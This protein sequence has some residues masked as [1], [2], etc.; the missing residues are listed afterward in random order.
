MAKK[1]FDTNNQV[2]APTLIL[3]SKSGE[4][5]G[6]IDG[7]TE[8][9]YRKSL[10]SADEL[11]FNVSKYIDGKINHLWNS[12]SDLKTIYLPE[13]QERFQIAVSYHDEEIE[14]KSVTGTS[15]C[16]AELS[17]ILL[18][19]FSCNTEDDLEARDY[20]VTVFYNPDDTDHS[21]LN[22]V[23]HDKVSHYSIGHVDDSL[24]NLAF[25]FTADKQSIY[26]FLT[27]DIAEH[28]QCLFIFDSMTRTINAYDLLST[29]NDC[30]EDTIVR[31]YDET[32]Q[33][34]KKHYRD[35]FHDECPKCHSKNIT[36]GYGRD[37]TI[38]IDRENLS[39]EMVR[40]SDINSLKNCLYVEGGDDDINAAFIM[41]NPNGSQY[42]YYFSPEVL[43][44]MPEEF[45]DA[46]QKYN[47]LYHNYYYENIIDT[48][49][50]THK[51]YQE[52][53]ATRYLPGRETP[54]VYP[55][56]MIDT[57][58]DSNN[59]DSSYVTAFNDVVQYISKLSD[60][61]PYTDYEPYRSDTSL[62]GQSALVTAYFNSIDLESFVQTK[63][64]PTYEMEVY[65][66]HHALSLLTSEN[67]GTVSVSG[68]GSGTVKTVVENAILQAAKTIIN[69]ALFKVSIANSS[70][71][72][73]AGAD[74]GKWNGR[75]TITD[76]QD[77]NPTTNTV[78]GSADITITVDGNVE[79]YCKNR[80]KYIMSQ[81][82]LPVANNLYD[83]SM[84]ESEIH[85]QILL[86]SIDNLKI[87]SNVM[88]SC[89]D[90]LM[91]KISEIT[92]RSIGNPV[93]SKLT[94]YYE[95]YKRRQENITARINT[96]SDYISKVHKFGLLML[97]YISEVQNILD[98]QKYLE[99]YSHEHK[100]QNLWDVF[101]YYRREDTYTNENIISDSL[102]TNAD[103]VQY[104]GY[105]MDFA[106][107]EAVKAGTPQITIS[108]TLNNL[109]ALPEFSPIIDSF[110]VGNW[111]RVRTDIQNDRLEDPI[112]KLRL[113]SYK[114]SFDD[115]QSIDVEFSTATNTW[116]GLRDV[117]DV[118]ASAQSMASS[119]TT[120]AKQVDKNES[121]TATVNRW[122]NN[123]LDLTNQKI[124]SDAN[125]Q[126]ILIDEHGILGRRYDD[127][128]DVYDPC[129]I[130]ILNNGLYTTHDD[131][132]TIDAGVGK[133]MWKNPDKDWAEEE[134][135]GIIARK[136]VGEQ[137]LGEDLRITNATGS[138]T[139]DVNGLV[140]KNSKNTIS[141]NPNENAFEIRKGNEKQ[142][143]IDTDGNINLSG[144]AKI[145]WANITDAKSNVTQITKDTI[146]TENL[147]ANN[148][149]VNAANIQGKLIAE[150]IDTKGLIAENI[151]GNT[152]TGKTINGGQINIGSGNFVVDSSGNLITK[153]TMSLGN[154]KLTYDGS[155]LTVSGTINAIGG[156]FSGNITSTGT[157]TGG[158]IT[159]TDIIAESFKYEDEKYIV[160]LSEGLEI[161]NKSE[162]VE[163]SYYIKGSAGAIEISANDICFYKGKSIPY[164]DI[165]SIGYGDGKFY[166][167]GSLELDNNIVVYGDTIRIDCGST[168]AVYL[169]ARWID[170]SI[171][172]ILS[173]DTDGL[174]TYLGWSGTGKDENT[175]T[176][177]TVLRGSSVRLKS[178]TGTTVSSDERL[179]NSFKPLNE[180]SE[181]FMDLPATAFKYNNGQSGRYHFGFK[182]QDVRDAFL[183]HGYTTQDFGGFVQMTDNPDNEDY[184]GIDD[185]MGL[186]YTEFTAWNT[187]MIQ[188]LYKENEILK[189]R[190]S[191]LEQATV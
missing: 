57:T 30:Y 65:D 177:C 156:T 134:T 142:L 72:Y 2:D 174:T 59:P 67:I 47:D 48:A 38:L 163:T 28:M 147:V 154:G 34:I 116:S 106:K 161:I 94:E 160:E 81:S 153:G 15:L 18:R 180:F 10:M 62:T 4:R 113:L 7:A 183:K 132:E 133:F 21:L 3:E 105:L 176:T 63:M 14:T 103:V 119:Y 100:T 110:D 120:I 172:S 130:K 190:I 92:D 52:L 184:C 150:Q 117:Q 71:T 42:V 171:H 115:V 145:S 137:L 68:F 138:L 78:T 135:Y 6:S 31:H 32:G 121:A 158:T 140:V 91:E 16:E 77:D 102:D 173:R 9:T 191:Q 39:T 53:E 8:I 107:K 111:I 159:G 139:F 181:V 167:T 20:R 23:L 50:T 83:L 13:Y 123:G 43:S 114:I 17:Q 87:I 125:N 164:Y 143:Y 169:S 165:G 182:A 27:G 144:D 75:F 44:E 168:N 45:L 124:V 96:L 36:Q 12:I 49:K 11:S 76:L 5:Y 108:T 185:P 79:A 33:E 112:Y 97:A 73:I 141:I 54:T 129:Q 95:K 19:D 118:I 56:R 35:D 88:Q 58:F 85:S 55:E 99:T 175:Y 70:Y 69:T 61:K 136:I 149:K 179:K 82:D 151:S 104:A 84:S 60:K 162:N 64:A 170:E 122:V 131:W 66:K 178:T 187:H 186:V 128:S 90:V 101:N 24:R 37:T 86:Y 146:A 109:L 166:L 89:M 51:Y 46:Y 74:S 188:E 40:E 41:S 98:F 155:S 25:E 148:L 93:Y 26:D 157:I 1:L 189:K 152:I 22:R 127:I 80:I 126:N 29:C